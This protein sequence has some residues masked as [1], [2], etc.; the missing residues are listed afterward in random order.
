[1]P[2]AAARSPNLAEPFEIAPGIEPNEP[3]RSAPILST[4]D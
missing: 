4:I 2:L 1:M 3:S